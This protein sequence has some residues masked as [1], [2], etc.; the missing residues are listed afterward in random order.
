MRLTI[1]ASGTTAAYISLGVASAYELWAFSSDLVYVILFPQ[2]FSV[3]YLRDYCNTYGALAGY[4]V[5]VLTRISA[6]EA[7]IP[8]T[9]AMK[10][11]VMIVCSYREGK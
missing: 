3:V 5:G 9:A 8:I 6:G 2:L 10:Y 11:A 1:V 4:A 7:K